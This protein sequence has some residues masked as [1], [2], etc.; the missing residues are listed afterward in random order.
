M[1]G[2]S[3]TYFHS[4]RSQ[5]DVFSCHSVDNP[6]QN[7]ELEMLKVCQQ[8]IPC[9]LLISKQKYAPSVDTNVLTKLS[10]AFADLRILADE[11]QLHLAY[12]C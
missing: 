11:V 6:D 2:A 12:E 3:P 1:V 4:H 10:S 5:G 8:L 9:S 7:A